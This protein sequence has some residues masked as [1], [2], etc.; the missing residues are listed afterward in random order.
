MAEQLTLSAFAARLSRGAPK[1]IQQRLRAHFVKTALKMEAKAKQ[2]ASAR[3]RVRS[4]LLRRSIQ[5]TV[6]EVEGN[7]SVVLKAGGGT[8]RVRYAAVQEE[9]T[10]ILPGGALKPKRGRNLAI[11]TDRALTPSGVSKGGPRRFNNLRFA[12]L[13]GKK[14]LVDKDSGE[15]YFWLVREVRFKGKKFL[16]DAF[17]EVFEIEINKVPSIVERAVTDAILRGV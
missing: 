3:L 11:P 17:D 12:L 9:G 1:L 7:L 8:S 15:V 10:R 2:N 4:G 14:A 6:E 13:G 5:G 16:R